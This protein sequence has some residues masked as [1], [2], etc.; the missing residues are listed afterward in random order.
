[1][2]FDYE[3]RVPGSSS[4]M[5]LAVDGD[6]AALNQLFAACIPRLRNV[7]ARLLY[8]QQDSEDAL[9]EGLLSA[10]RH[11]KQFRGRAQFTT[12]MHSIVV[13]AAKSKLRRR[14]AQPPISSLDDVLFENGHSCIA[15][16]VADPHSNFEKEYEKKEKKR[17]LAQ[18]IQELPPGWRVIV[19]LYD[20]EGIQMSEIA[21]R[22]G[23]S[24]SAVKTRH[25]R[26]TRLLF[27]IVNDAFAQ[28][29]TDAQAS[30]RVPT[31]E[32]SIAGSD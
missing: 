23:L 16:M 19:R 9:Q 30:A 27:T 29:H 5:D 21:A 13:N 26:A 28:R 1:M 31:P 14:W 6:A 20:I 18:A 7:A 8:N 25:F 15:D 3:M 12:W 10:F 24:L 4:A 2:D 11:L 17:I 22:L 32:T